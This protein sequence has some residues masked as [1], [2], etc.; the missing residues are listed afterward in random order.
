MTDPS[1]RSINAEVLTHRVS[2]MRALARG[3][4]LG[5]EYLDAVQDSFVEVLSN[6][7][8]RGDS[9]FAG[10]VRNMA[11]RRTRAAAR[12]SKAETAAARPESLPSAADLVQEME[13][14][15]HITDAVLT[16]SDPQ[17]EVIVLRFWHD[18]P[19]REIASK[20]DVSVHTVKSRLQL[21]I[22]KLRQRLD[23]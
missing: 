15:R 17:R 23:H 9:W 21:A 22:D 5:D 19:P 2:A 6:G 1:I 11:S 8:D 10:I 14:Q 4:V 18:L 16:L 7:P 12:R 3:L 20:L 13:L